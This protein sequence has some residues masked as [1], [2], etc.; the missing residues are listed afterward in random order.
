MNIFRAILTDNGET[1]LVDAHHENKKVSHLFVHPI[2]NGIVQPMQHLTDVS[3]LVDTIE[4]ALTE[5]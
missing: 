5:I 2:Q 4:K 3:V 1:F